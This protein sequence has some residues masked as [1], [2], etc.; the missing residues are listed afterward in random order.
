MDSAMCDC[1]YNLMFKYKHI[2][3][4]VARAIFFFDRFETAKE[5]IREFAA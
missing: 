2:F 3:F 4:D 5:K 1:M